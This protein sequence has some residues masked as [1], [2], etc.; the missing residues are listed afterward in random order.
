[1][2][3]PFSGA[4]VAPLLLDGQGVLVSAVGDGLTAVADALDAVVGAL[5][6]G[7]LAHDGGG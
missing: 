7:P 5:A 4:V 6:M 2:I 3:A 1:M